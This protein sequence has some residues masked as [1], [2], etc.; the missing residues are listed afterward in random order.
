MKKIATLLMAFVAMTAFSQDIKIWK[1]EQLMQESE[2]S[3]HKIFDAEQVIDEV[4]A[5]PKTKDFVNAYNMAGRIEMRILKTEIEKA[6]NKQPLDTLLFVKTLDKVVKSFSE[7]SRYNNTPNAKGKIKLNKEVEANNKTSLKQMLPYYAFAG[8]FLHSNGDKDGA[9]KAFTQYLDMPKLP[10]FTQA[11]TDSI[12][13]AGAETY[14]RVGYFAAM[15]AFEKKDYENTMKY[16]DFAIADST[17]ADDGY[18]MKLTCLLHKGDTAQW[19]EVSKK[20]IA[21]VSTNVKYTQNLLY[22][23]NKENMKDE[24]MKL[25]EDIVAQA[26]NNPM[27][28]YARGCVFMDENKNEVARDAFKKAI[29]LDSSFA[30]AYY[31]LGVTYVNEFRELNEKIPTSFRDPKYIDGQKQALALCEKAKEN[32]EQVSILAPEQANLWQA[33]LDNVNHNI[34]AINGNIKRVSDYQRSKK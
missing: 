31:N 5:N 29:E 10:I 16:V 3:A 17:S 21:A 30:N 7:S 18:F 32:F 23:Y 2:S 14:G 22:Y 11:E 15:L 24:A 12:F 28:W 6:Q 34:E 13:K 4:L 27:A 33:K 19:V 1:A 25:A 26:P 20:A 9:F 8:Q